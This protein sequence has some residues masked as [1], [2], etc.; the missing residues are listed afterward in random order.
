MSPLS[1]EYTVSAISS[2]TK[3]LL[4]HVADIKSFEEV[5]L[6]ISELYDFPQT[7]VSALFVSLL[8]S[9]VCCV[10][11]QWTDRY[12]WVD[13]IWSLAPVLYAWHFT[14]RSAA[15]WNVD[16]NP[17]TIIASSFITAWG[18]RLT[19]NFYRKGGYRWM[20]QD[21]RWPYIRE[22]MN[23]V[24]MTLLNVT[25]ISF[26]QNILLV[27]LVAPVYICACYPGT[28]LNAID[29]IATIVVVVSL[30]L[31]IIADQQQWQF[32]SAKHRLIASKKRL[33][34]A[35]TL[36]FNT[37][38]LFKYS[39]HPNFLGEQVFWY[40]IYLYSVAASGVWLQ[41]SI[42]GTIALTLLFQASTKLTEQISLSKYPK[43]QEYIETTNRFIPW[44]PKATIRRTQRTPVKKKE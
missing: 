17:R 34:G 38:G 41:W 37:V 10:L 22:K 1:V 7:L 33:T 4:E 18:L 8:L 11:G 24:M 20:D 13:K 32:Q 44:F 6:L 36:G 2:G 25:F 35:Y 30:S 5:K 27:V 19:Y 43:Y 12:S 23:V 15:L 40:G 31:E 9:M 28:P 26:A 21:Y 29:I 14:L 16:I 39:R 42:A 3:H